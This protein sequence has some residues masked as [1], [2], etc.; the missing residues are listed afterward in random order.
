M[1]QSQNV[2]SMKKMLFSMRHLRSRWAAMVH[3]I[4]MIPVAWIL[5]YWL[6]YNLSDIPTEFITKALVLIPVVIVVQGLVF[7]TFGL[8]RGVWRFASIPDL[9]RIV[10]AVFF[11]TL[12]L[13][14][15][16]FIITRLHYVPRSVFVFYPVLLIVMLGAPR[17]IY[18]LIKDRKFSAENTSRVLVVGAGA[19]GEMLVR[20]LLK[21]APRL[22]EP[23]AFVDDDQYKLGKEIH[24]IRVVGGTDSIPG[25]ADQLAIDLIL[26]ALPSATTEQ[27]RT[28]VESCEQASVPFRTLP[29]LQDLVS[30]QTSPS[31][32]REVLIDDLLGRDP[33]RLRWDKVKEGLTG[34][35][36]LVTGGGGSIGSELC[37]QLA[38]LTPSTLILYER[39]EFNLYSIE[40]DLRS[41]FPHVKFYAILGDVCD[42]SNLERVF[43][44][45]RPNYVFH[46]A[47]YK[48][49]PMLEDQVREA[50][51][52]NVIGTKCVA[53]AA[54][55]YG[56][57]TFI[58]ISTDKA[59]NPTNVMGTTKRI[60]EVY[61]Q[62]LNEHSDVQFITVRFGNVLGS[63]GSVVPLFKKQ[64]EKGGPVTVTHPDVTRYFMTTSEACQLILQSSV[65][66]KGGEIFVLDMGEPVLVRYLAEQLIR[67]SG[68]KPG[69]D[70][71]IIYTGLR[72]GEKL[73]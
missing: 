65:I 27:M 4:L 33:V 26:L 13:A 69:Q 41:E 36:I 30:G 22:H 34:H 15:G 48:H 39:S 38:S 19:A 46:A 21:N 57:E 7:V 60:A 16:I 58:L 67:L 50:V 49:V 72:P 31:A 2:T 32:L 52:N 47:A 20:D 11:G 73:Y 61:C 8:Y 66:G 1:N 24:G 53:L 43:N 17:F 6:R 23:V 44:K 59:V 68:R 64:I 62:T 3:D 63:A 9:V 5:A 56:T 70:I 35:S 40:N 55:K 29:K 18:R 37:R 12:I 71:K 51:S 28:I 42:S 10:K 25:L 14:F 45:Y 54:Q